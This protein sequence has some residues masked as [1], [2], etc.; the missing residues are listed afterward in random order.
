MR[1]IVLTIMVIFLTLTSSGCKETENNEHTVRYQ[2][3]YE[4]NTI[5][6]IAGSGLSNPQTNNRMFVRSIQGDYIY[7]A[8]E[9]YDSNWDNTNEEAIITLAEGDN[10]FIIVVIPKN[11]D[12]PIHYILEF[13]FP[14]KNEILAEL[15][16][17]MNNNEVSINDEWI[18]TTSEYPGIHLFAG[19]HE[20]LDFT[21]GTLFM[22][23]I[24]RNTE[25]SNVIYLCIDENNI[26]LLVEFDNEYSNQRVVYRFDN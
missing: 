21:F 3:Y 20:E 16:N 6:F 4:A 8:D 12:I 25:N 18:R 15:D 5:E 17:Y 26:P 11:V 19:Y 24:A 9:A 23:Y 7:R 22:L 14:T 10:G 2:Y 13:Q 1:R